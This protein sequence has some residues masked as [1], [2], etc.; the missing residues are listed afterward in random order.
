MSMAK[1]LYKPGNGFLG[2]HGDTSKGIINP[3]LWFLDDL[4]IR[5][6]HGP[7]TK[8]W[9][10]KGSALTAF[11]SSTKVRRLL[12]IR[13]SGTKGYVSGHESSDR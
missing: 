9:F 11:V 12:K 10:R 4:A 8:W 2:P 1:T 6:S 13:S 3:S 5:L 7:T